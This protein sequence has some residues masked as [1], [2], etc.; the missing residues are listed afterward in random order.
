M[1]NKMY[2]IRVNGARS[3]E[4]VVEIIT[5]VRT[6]IDRLVGQAEA[7][8]RDPSV[9]DGLLLLMGKTSLAL[10]DT[11][12]ENGKDGSFS[13]G[14]DIVGKSKETLDKIQGVNNVIKNTLQALNENSGQLTEAVTEALTG[15]TKEL[16]ESYS[17]KEKQE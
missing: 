5:K 14:F 13:K 15:A 3:E 10:L 1:A 2:P 12:I 16:V 11:A 6:A 9:L 17:N 4:E 8:D 7:P